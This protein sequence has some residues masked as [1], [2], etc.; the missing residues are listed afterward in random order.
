MASIYICQNH[1][2]DRGNV[3]DFGEI[4]CSNHDRVVVVIVV[5]SCKKRGR[6]IRVFIAVYFQYSIIE[7]SGG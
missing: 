6:P 1:M 3:P 4:H 7:D 2:L 5:C